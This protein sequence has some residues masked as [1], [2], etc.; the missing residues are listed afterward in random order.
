MLESK[1][2]PKFKK[3]LGFIGKWFKRL[4]IFTVVAFG[5]AGLV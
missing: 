3:I 2:Q 4:L 1:G 5:I